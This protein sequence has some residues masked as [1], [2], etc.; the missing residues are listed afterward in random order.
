MVDR[1]SYALSD[2][3]C[4]PVNHKLAVSANLWFPPHEHRKQC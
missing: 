1:L 4:L 2:R 3:L